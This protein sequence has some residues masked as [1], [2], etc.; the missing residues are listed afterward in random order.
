LSIEDR[1]SESD[2]GFP[3]YF[4]HHLGRFRYRYR[5]YR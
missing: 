3:V 1:V 2:K 4:G 5:G